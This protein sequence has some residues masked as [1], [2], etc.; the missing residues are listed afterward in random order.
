[1]SNLIPPFTDP[2]LPQQEIE[3]SREKW[4]RAGYIPLIST[5][6]GI[7]RATFNGTHAFFNGAAAILGG[8]LAIGTLFFP[9]EASRQF[10]KGAIGISKICS[11]R[12]FAYLRGTVR[13]SVEAIPFAGNLACYSWDKRHAWYAKMKGHVQWLKK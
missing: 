9:T 1:M 6:T 3:A 4:R 8:A 13:G 11:R 2:H 5:I 7:T 10:R 12:A